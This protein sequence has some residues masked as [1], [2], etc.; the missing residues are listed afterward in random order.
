VLDQLTSLLFTAGVP[1][2]PGPNP[3]LRAQALEL[4]ESPDRLRASWAGVMRRLQDEGFE[5]GEFALLCRIYLNL[6]DNCAALLELLGG[7]PDHLQLPPEKLRQ[8]AS[9]IKTHQEEVRPLYEL[10]TRKPPPLDPAKL[11]AA[12]RKH[13]GAPA[14][15]V[16]ELIR[17]IEA[18]EVAL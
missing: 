6:L 8:A 10:A 2:A 1:R 13:A 7:L 16:G 3:D 4:L 14:V 5:A 11:A 12:E 15:E 18:G 9:D 17:Q